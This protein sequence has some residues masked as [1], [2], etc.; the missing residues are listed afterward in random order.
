MILFFYSLLLLL[1]GLG[2]KLWQFGAT[3]YLLEDFQ[4]DLPLII[5]NYLGI[6]ALWG[7]AKKRK[8]GPRLFW[9]VYFIALLIS[10]FAV[11]L[12]DDTLHA[13]AQQYG[14][15]S[16]MTSFGISLLLMC[17]YYWGVFDFAFLTAT[18]GKRK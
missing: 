16:V 7:R 18:K 3:A 14:W 8:L 6:I 13:M 15:L 11:P 4:F 9:K 1:F 2:T 10:I 17:P 5:F 12:F